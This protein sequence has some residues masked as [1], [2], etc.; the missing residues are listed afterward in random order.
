MI[1]FDLTTINSSLE[2]R[3]E[4]RVH[5]LLLQSHE[6]RLEEKFKSEVA[7]KCAEE[8]VVFVHISGIQ[9][10]IEASVHKGYGRRRG[11]KLCLTR[12]LTVYRRKIRHL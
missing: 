12:L 10:P 11:L 2:V 7:E 6:K 1:D 3:E 8:A 9:F 4:S 5:K